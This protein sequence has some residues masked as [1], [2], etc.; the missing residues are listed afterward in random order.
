MSEN[1]GNFK[2]SVV[3]RSEEAL[4]RAVSLAMLD[5]RALA[6]KSDGDAIVFF[7]SATLDKE[8]SALP[9]QLTSVE[10]LPMVKAW[11][12][13]H[14]PPRDK[15]PNIDGSTSEGFALDTEMPEIGYSAFLRVKA[16]WAEHHK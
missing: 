4:E 3:A 15:R 2:V 1:M 5:Y 14:P 12:R 16:I 11:L 9:S 6:W 10:V 8:V 7:W 13:A